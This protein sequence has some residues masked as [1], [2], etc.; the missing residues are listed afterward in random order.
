MP[1]GDM[2]TGAEVLSARARPTQRGIPPTRPA[3][4]ALREAARRYVAAARPVPPLSYSE[5]VLHTARLMEV[6]GGD[7]A[8]HK[9][10]SVVL[11]NEA[12]RDRLAAV[13]FD[14]RL[15]LLPKCLRDPVECPGTFDGLGLVCQ[16]CGRCPL[17]EIKSEA[18]RLGYAVLISEGTAVVAALIRAGKV[19]GVI[20]V[21]CLS[22]LEE[23]FPLMEAAAVPA[24]AIPLLWDGCT[25]TSVDLDWVWDAIRLAS[26]PGGMRLDLDA[27]REEVRGWFTAEALEA[28]LGP[29]ADRTEAV[30]RR[31][32]A[33][34]GKRWRPLLVAGAYRALAQDAGT[35][36]PGFV[37]DAA[38][39][40]ECFHKASLVHDDI[41]DGDAVRYGEKTL[42]EQHGVPVALNVGDFLLGEGYR[43][44]ARAEVPAAEK[45]EMLAAAAHGHRE[46]CLGQGAELVWARE[47]RPLAP[48][49][50]LDIFR[51]KTA[52]A[53]AVALR[54]GAACAG[55][56]RLVWDALDRYAEALGVAYQIRDDLQDCLGPT[57]D[58][59]A[60]AARPSIVLALA[61]ERAAGTDRD[62]LAAL[63]QRPRGTEGVRGPGY[64]VLGHDPRPQTPDPGIRALLGRLDADKAVRAMMADYE[65]VAIQALEPL[66]SADLKGLLRRVITRI[67]DGATGEAPT[68]E[69]EAPDALDRPR[70]GP[71]AR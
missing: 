28:S 57:G 13:P 19:Q 33:R 31:W 20:G 46:L 54:I 9:W 61:Y 23:V 58:G 44:I 47:P 14:R 66:S 59:D 18:E 32:L 41:E 70:G 63:W 50:V 16:G 60:Q 7:A 3:R 67:F 10:L 65:R 8:L 26:A 53:F 27:L 49:E 22:A 30:A 12:W 5:L 42:H 51:K 15:L 2:R 1:K 21:G 64:G 11:N 25:S 24:V 52:P 48:A 56:R 6:A 17:H 39:A 43:L 36:L 55:A 45:A 71:A 37:R 62:R 4:E 29:E 69:P 34:S 40:V 35:P 68:R 38:L